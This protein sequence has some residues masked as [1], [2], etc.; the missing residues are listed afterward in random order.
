MIITNHIN[1]CNIFFI[2]LISIKLSA[3]NHPN[4]V[5]GDNRIPG[6]V[7]RETTVRRINQWSR[8]LAD[9]ESVDGDC[10]ELPTY[11]AGALA[12]DQSGAEYPP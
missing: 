4:V 2:F 10:F 3:F 6:A 1:P 7:T 12:M 11:L 5:N 8:Q 9:G